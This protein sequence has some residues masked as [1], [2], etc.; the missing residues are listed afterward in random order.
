MSSNSSS[1]LTNFNLGGGSNR[2]EEESFFDL[3]T[4]TDPATTAASTN[5]NPTNASAASSSGHQ[6]FTRQTQAQ[7][8]FTKGNEVY[9][10]DGSKILF[11]KDPKAYIE[12]DGIPYATALPTSQH[13]PQNLTPSFSFGIDQFLS[14]TSTSNL[15]PI[16]NQPAPSSYPLNLSQLSH[17]PSD[18][19]SVGY[20]F[21]IPAGTSSQ[22]T[23]S[24]DFRDILSSYAD[25]GVNALQH[26]NPPSIPSQAQQTESQLSFQK[27]LFESLS[28][29]VGQQQ[30]QEDDAEDD[31]EGFVDAEEGEM[32]AFQFGDSISQQHFGRQRAEEAELEGSWDDDDDDENDDEDDDEEDIDYSEGDDDEDLDLGSRD[33]N[34]S[35]EFDLSEVV[36]DENSY[37]SGHE[38]NKEDDTPKA[39]NAFIIY[40]RQKF[41][42]LEAVSEDDLT[43]SEKAQLID[44][45][46]R[47]EID[48]VKVYYQGLAEEAK[49]RLAEKYP[50]PSE[51][52]NTS[53]SA[54]QSSTIL[55]R[56]TSQPSQQS[57]SP[58]HSPTSQPRSPNTLSNFR[59]RDSFPLFLADSFQETGVN[60]PRPAATVKP[61]TKSSTSTVPMSESTTSATATPTTGGTAS[62]SSKPPP[63]S[64][65][66]VKSQRKPKNPSLEPPQEKTEAE[67]QA[68]QAKLE[69]KREKM[70]ERSKAKDKRRR[71]RKKKQ[72]KHE[73]EE[74]ARQL[75]GPVIEKSY[76]FTEVKRARESR[77]SSSKGKGK[78][79]ASGN[80]KL[81]SGSKANAGGSRAG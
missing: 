4:N 81:D 12:K 15:P 57:R 7:Q 5:I 6:P 55:T 56:E 54:S 50:I 1:S 17:N 74:R 70:R 60:A 33:D 40:R 71:E 3:M 52:P 42:A 73:A 79:T 18:H 27:S 65:V 11:P 16:A 78:A 2:N 29:L 32:T 68:E 62:T 39:P 63:E 41:R 13:D 10:E 76:D 22:Q 80:V 26:Y 23:H 21:T 8:Q 14:S 51:V 72:A 58:A 36:E 44:N 24:H 67:I 35:V 69:E 75:G 53:N 61:S 9:T 45:L 19:Q 43:L 47:N 20:D 28:M 64:R 37:L 66:K 46:W 59:F 77:G 38:E 49:R 31:E 48:G 30:E 34:V 25:V